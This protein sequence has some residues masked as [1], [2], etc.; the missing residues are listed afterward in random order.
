MFLSRTSGSAPASK[1]LESRCVCDMSTW[2]KPRRDNTGKAVQQRFDCKTSRDLNEPILQH[3]EITAGQAPAPPSDPGVTA[4]ELVRNTAVDGK[5]HVVREG[6]LS[7]APRDWRTYCGWRFGRECAS[8]E[9]TAS[10]TAAPLCPSCF[11]LKKPA[12]GSASGVTATPSPA[13]A[14][15]ESSGS[16]SLDASTS[17]PSLP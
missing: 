5:L 16:S 3:S 12:S 15:T 8:A 17:L 6:R 7:V 11:N 9:R 14:D 1:L 2:A 13:A 4:H 10:W